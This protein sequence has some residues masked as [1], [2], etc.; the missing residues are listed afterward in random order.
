MYTL[1]RR[2]SFKTTESTVNFSPI[3]NGTA[4]SSALAC[5]LQIKNDT[6]NT[7]TKTLHNLIMPFPPRCPGRPL[8][9]ACPSRKD[10]HFLGENQFR[11][12]AARP[13]TL[14]HRSAKAD[15]RPLVRPRP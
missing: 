14:R 5:G 13:D 12:S 1:M 9:P 8:R 11:N 10:R 7:G 3:T 2:F 6:Q 15:G 4:F